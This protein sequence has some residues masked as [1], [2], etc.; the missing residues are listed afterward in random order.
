MIVVTVL[1]SIFNQMELYLVQNLNE[2]CHLDHIPFNLRGNKNQFFNSFFP[3]DWK[4]L[5]RLSERLEPLSL[6]GALNPL[7]PYYHDVREVSGVSSVMPPSNPRC[8]SAVMFEWFQ[9]GTEMGSHD[10]ERCN[11][12]RELCDKKGKNDWDNL[13]NVS[14]KKF[15]I[16]RA[17]SFLLKKIHRKSAMEINTKLN[18]IKLSSVIQFVY[19]YRSS[20]GVDFYFRR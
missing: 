12:L 2:N 17:V 8:Y 18:Y 7:V 15:P 19:F 4:F 1:L 9:G 20:Y 11:S 13:I 16:S 6:M 5:H 14:F 10:D 3:H